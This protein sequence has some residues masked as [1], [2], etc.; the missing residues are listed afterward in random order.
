[1]RPGPVVAPEPT[2]HGDGGPSANSGRLFWY[3]AVG[4]LSFVVDFG[5]LVGLRQLAHT[6]VW[7]ATTAGYWTGFIVNFT[8]QRRVT[9]GARGAIGRHF[10]RYGVLVVI[11]FVGT[12]LIVSAANAIGI[13]YA[14][15]KVLAV[16]MFV[17]INY[18]VYSAWVFKDGNPD[19]A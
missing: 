2:A 4:G 9:F 17:V 14:T 18:K 5:V 13:G 6:P 19:R 10:W 12:L 8:L 16:A 15:G 7:L 1:M 11:N 3:L